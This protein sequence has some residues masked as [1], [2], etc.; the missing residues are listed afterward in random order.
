MQSFWGFLLAGIAVCCLW[1]APVRAEAPRVA[2]EVVV[3]E[4]AGKLVEGRVRGHVLRIDQP[5][6]FGGEDTA[7]TPPETFAFSLGACFVAAARY[8]AW[9]E[10]LEV[11]NVR[12]TVRGVLDYG[13]AMGLSEG[14][15]G[16]PG[17]TLQAGFD[18]PWSEAEKAAFLARVLERC[19][20][21]D[22]VRGLTPLRVELE[23]P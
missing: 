15:A 10:K 19:P 2:V 16:F 20:V 7:A 11:K 6:E 8:I 5:R 23:K 21:C 13:R 12:A 22:N 4:G 3:Q 14:R 18:A 17:F 1:A 9:L